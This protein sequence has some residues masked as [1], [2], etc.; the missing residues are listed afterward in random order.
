MGEFSGHT[1]CVFSLALDRDGQRMLTGGMDGTVRLWRVSDAPPAARELAAIPKGASLI[2]T[3]E[4]E[5]F[6]EKEG[7]TYVR[8]LSGQGNDALCDKVRF[9]PEGRAG[10]GLINAGN[11]HLKLPRS[12]VANQAS[13]TVAAWVRLVMT[14]G[15]VS[16]S[17]LLAWT[18]TSLAKFAWLLFLFTPTA[19][20]RGARAIERRRAEKSVQASR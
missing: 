3:F 2:M 19:G 17:L 8:D 14:I 5:T 7:K 15:V 11:G 10:G 16:L 4:K 12:L 13:F 6:Y 20:H 9:T 18:D 1:A